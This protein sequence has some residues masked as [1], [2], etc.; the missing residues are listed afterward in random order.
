MKHERITVDPKVM[1]G[2]P[3]IAGT[4]IPVEKILRELGNGLS[5]DDILREYPRLTVADILAA[6][7]FAADYMQDWIEASDRAGGA[8]EGAA[9]G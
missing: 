6:Q 5:Y 9:A 7:R 1:A 4:R 2:K 3:V 8:K